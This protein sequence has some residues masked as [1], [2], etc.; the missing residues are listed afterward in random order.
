MRERDRAKKF[1][2]GKSDRE[3]IRAML[4]RR[5]I[6]YV[7]WNREFNPRDDQ[8]TWITF[9]GATRD[10]KEVKVE[11]M[12]SVHGG[13][14]LDYGDPAKQPKGYKRLTFRQALKRVR[15]DLQSVGM[16]WADTAAPRVR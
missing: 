6:A 13:L 12:F 15:D 4:K 7:E 9:F 10:G 11:L 2:N 14:S 16:R 8:P 1:L 3:L 5:G